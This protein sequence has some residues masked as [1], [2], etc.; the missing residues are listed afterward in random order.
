MK[1]ISPLNRFPRGSHWYGIPA[2]ICLSLIAQYAVADRGDT[3]NVTGGSTFLYDTNVFR[4]SN[5]VPASIVGSDTKSDLII[6]TTGTLSWDKFYC[7]QRFEGNG[8]L[9]DSR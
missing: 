6:S 4:L 8:S 7:M 9:G 2:I 3:L 5:I 1:I